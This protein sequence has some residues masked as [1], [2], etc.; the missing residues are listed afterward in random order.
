[1][2]ACARWRKT[3]MEGTSSRQNEPPFVFV[4]SNLMRPVA[5][6]N[7]AERT[8]A[9]GA[10]TRA[11]VAAGVVAFAAVAAVAAVAGSLPGSSIR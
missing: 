11:A 1:M 9:K 4:R 10:S 8:E 3:R 2:G 6:S 5:Q 7:A